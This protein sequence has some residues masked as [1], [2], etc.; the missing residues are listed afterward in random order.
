MKLELQDT[1]MFRG[2]LL[3]IL[4]YGEQSLCKTRSVEPSGQKLLSP[5]A[6]A[7]PHGQNTPTYKSDLD[8]GLPPKPFASLMRREE[9]FN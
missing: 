6:R 9:K 1:E 7:S 4:A 8:F 3:V 2:S 5:S